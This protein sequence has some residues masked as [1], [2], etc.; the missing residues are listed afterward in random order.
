MNLR[1]LLVVL[2]VICLGLSVRP[3]HG[4]GASPLTLEVKAGYDESGHYRVD[5]WFPVTVVVANDG[6]D[7]QA[8]LE[9][10]FAGQSDATVRYE[11]DLPRG[12][13]KGLAFP[14]MAN[15][16]FRTANVTLVVG[17]VTQARVPIRLEPLAAQQTTIGVVSTDPTL[18]NS[19]AGATINNATG[20]PILHL[21][22]RRLPS[23]AALLAGL[24]VLFI[25]NV[26]TADLA[27][28]QR[29]AIAAWTRLGGQ[30]VVSG[31]T[32][33]AQT[34]PGLAELLPVTVGALQP[35]TS[36]AALAALVANPSSKLLPT[37]TVSAVTLQPGATKLDRNSLLT[38][39][40]V[41]A[42][43][44][45]FAAFDFAAL[46]TW[47]EEA[48]LW[49]NVLPITPRMALGQAFRSRNDNLLR[50]ALNLPALRLPSIGLLLLLMSS[51]IVVVGPVNFLLLRRLRR[52]ELAW[53]TTPLLVL[54][55]TAAAYGSSFVIRGVRPQIT[56]FAIIQ[57]DEGQTQGQLTAFLSLF[58]PQRHSYR[59]DF[60]PEVLVTPGTFE[61]ARFQPATVTSDG[62]V[63]GMRE[64][65]VDVSALR[66]LLLEAPTNAV[67]VVQSSLTTDRDGTVRG[68]VRLTGERPLQD[69]LLVIGSS[70]QALGDLQTG[71]T[72]EV[73]LPPDLENFPHEFS[74]STDG[75]IRRSQIINSLFN[76]N[77]FDGSNVQGFPEAD[78][79]YVLGWADSLTLEPQIDGKVEP[80]Q[81]TTLYLI[82]LKS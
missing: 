65:L 54:G 36:T 69:A 48:T 30:L 62:N 26:A 57:G 51:Y 72:V 15:D 6:P 22:P 75:V 49:A 19:L 33:A 67:P 46:R 79:V 60:A 7:V 55:F 63:M 40:D 58:S 27:P 45:L 34:V 59:L 37:T 56:Q 31:G 70:A 44:V 4:Q 16:T 35:N 2:T 68:Q 43:R 24:D 71:A 66:T 1:S 10:R 52:V 32:S 29:G 42:G 21:D 77:R 74:F 23:D 14:V 20:T 12:A 3:A 81:G 9:W 73:K 5:A 82:R 41:G 17:G 50:D 53:V 64:L 28:A 25:H 78:G 80:Q 38:A 39:W 76:A 47:A 61:N 18:L 8:S 11:L 13:R